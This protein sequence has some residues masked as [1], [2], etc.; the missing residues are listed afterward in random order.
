MCFFTDNCKTPQFWLAKHSQSGKKTTFQTILCFQPC[1]QFVCPLAD[2]MKEWFYMGEQH[3][4]PTGWSGALTVSQELSSPTSES[5]LSDAPL[6]L[7]Q[8]Q[9][10]FIL[11]EATV[12]SF[13]KK[14]WMLSM[15]TVFTGM[16]TGCYFCYTSAFRASIVT[17]ISIQPVKIE[18]RGYYYDRTC[19]HNL[20]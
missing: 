3:P 1:Q 11:A 6:L 16:S 20:A 8:L 2:F 7:Q 19:I 15:S 13:V 18:H 12:P 14:T 17:T 9:T 10:S 5:D 4:T